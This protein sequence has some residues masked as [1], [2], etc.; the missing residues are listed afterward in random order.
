MGKR[1][2]R[3][4]A[5]SRLDRTDNEN[6]RKS[7]QGFFKLSNKSI[8]AVREDLAADYQA[9]LDRHLEEVAQI[10]EEYGATEV[11][12]AHQLQTHETDRLATGQQRIE[13]VELSDSSPEGAGP[14]PLEEP[15]V[16]AAPDNNPTLT[17]AS[18]S[19][20]IPITDATEGATPLHRTLDAPPQAKPLI[21]ATRE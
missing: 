17:Q 11:E 13:T 20:S 8:T 2:G 4:G 6:R 16:A 15:V 9:L 1:M 18:D 14:T 7:G 12:F 21:T 10:L 19:G 3:L 5:T